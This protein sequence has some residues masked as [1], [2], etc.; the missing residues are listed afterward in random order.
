MCEA[1]IQDG[2]KDP[3]TDVEVAPEMIEVGAAV[4]AEFGDELPIRELARLVF[5]AMDAEAN[6]AAHKPQA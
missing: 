6:A 2:A 5:Q 4:L 3:R 1:A